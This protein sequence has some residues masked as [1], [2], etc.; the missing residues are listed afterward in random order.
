[1]GCLSNILTTFCKCT[2]K[3]LWIKQLLCCPPPVTYP[4]YIPLSQ[5]QHVCPRKNR[6]RLARSKGLSQDL[7]YQDLPDT[8][9]VI[10]PSVVGGSSCRG[11]RL[12]TAA[13]DPSPE[14]N[15][16][17]APKILNFRQFRAWKHKAR[18]VEQES[19]SHQDRGLDPKPQT[20]RPYP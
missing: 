18:G 20:P 15:S 17:P 11:V 1:M 12:G 2:L 8:L 9:K 7:E 6:H 10:W 19:P 13:F 4:C 14:P 5:M 3:R 16:K